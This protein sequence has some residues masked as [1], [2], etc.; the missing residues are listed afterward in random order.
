MFELDYRE[1]LSRRRWAARERER[2]SQWEREQAEK[3]KLEAIERES[4]QVL[5]RI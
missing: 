1:E 4:R 2:V 5:W 3:D